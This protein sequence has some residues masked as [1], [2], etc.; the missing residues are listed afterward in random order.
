MTDFRNDPNFPSGE[1]GEYDHSRIQWAAVLVI[2]LLV[3]GVIIGSLWSGGGTQTAMNGPQ[4]ETTGSGG[5]SMGMQRPPRG[6]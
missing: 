2:L 6:Q 3:G 5:G 1:V 4:V